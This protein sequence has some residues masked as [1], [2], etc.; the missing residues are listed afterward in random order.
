MTL[1][2]PPSRV[3]KPMTQ[4]RYKLEMR[5]FFGLL[6]FWASIRIYF[7]ARFGIIGFEPIEMPFVA[8][9]G[10]LITHWRFRKNGD[11]QRENT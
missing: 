6:V 7:Y 3:G 4:G 8:A 11:T 10:M 2:Q 5:I 1:R 9:G